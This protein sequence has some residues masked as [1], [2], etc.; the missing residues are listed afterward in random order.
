MKYVFEQHQWINH[1]IYQKK[2]GYRLNLQ[3]TLTFFGLVDLTDAKICGSHPGQIILWTSTMPSNLSF[4]LFPWYIGEWGWET[5]CHWF[6]C[7][8]VAVESNENLSTIL[9]MFNYIITYDGKL[10]TGVPCPQNNYILT[11]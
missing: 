2:L 7:S 10:P 4:S 5:E 9:C 3:E 8:F 1:Y 11:R 6:S